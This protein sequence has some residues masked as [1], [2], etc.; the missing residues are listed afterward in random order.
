MWKHNYFLETFLEEIKNFG[1]E[2][3]CDFKTDQFLYYV[4]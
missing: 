1:L 3:V 2:K 4:W